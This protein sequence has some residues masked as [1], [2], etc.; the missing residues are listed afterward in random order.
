MNSWQWKHGWK[1]D[2]R[3]TKWVGAFQYLQA[4]CM[5]CTMWGTAR[6]CNSI[7]SMGYWAY[8]IL[9]L[10][11]TVKQYCCRA[12]GKDFHIKHYYCVVNNLLKHHLHFS[13]I[14]AIDTFFH[15]GLFHQA[16]LESGCEYTW[17]ALNDPTHEPE[18]YLTEVSEKLDCPTEDSNE[19]ADCLKT[20]TVDE[21][22][23][24]TFTCSVSAVKL[25][26]N[27]FNGM[28]MNTN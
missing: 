19:M 4:V 18:N 12:S 21:L 25:S 3:W 28:Q 13:G 7:Q 11:V 16:I 6:P 1:H 26:L 24:T 23:T 8:S 27:Y 14:I 5:Y 20:K 9:Q 17:W 10:L 2:W 22:R 15:L